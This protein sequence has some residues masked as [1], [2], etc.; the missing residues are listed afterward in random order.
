MK[1][2][3]NFCDATAYGTRDSLQMA[4]WVRAIFSAPKR[5]TITACPKHHHEWSERVNG[6]FTAAKVGGTKTQCFEDELEA[7]TNI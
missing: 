6:A 3:C 7:Q 4:G 5:I 1:I 2:A